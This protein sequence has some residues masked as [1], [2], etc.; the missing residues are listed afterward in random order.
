METQEVKGCWRDSSGG[1]KSLRHTKNVKL[2]FE[3][4][5]HRKV[6]NAQTSRQFIQNQ[7]TADWFAE[8]GPW[9]TVSSYA[10]SKGKEWPGELLFSAVSVDVQTWEPHKF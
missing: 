1:Q 4:K 9:D 6:D 7:Q 10:T 2:R 3:Q 5:P 8:G